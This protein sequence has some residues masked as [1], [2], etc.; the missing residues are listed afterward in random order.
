MLLKLPGSD[1]AV[2][3]ITLPL[4]SSLDADWNL[5]SLKKISTKW[6]LHIEDG[7]YCDPSRLGWNI[8]HSC[9]IFNNNKKLKGKK[10][11]DLV[12]AS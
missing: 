9:Y 2:K 11:P 8:A 5:D 4:S 7:I 10:L 6:K 1:F 3:M 12:F